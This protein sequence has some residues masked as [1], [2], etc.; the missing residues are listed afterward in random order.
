MPAMAYQGAENSFSQSPQKP[1]LFVEQLQQISDWEKYFEILDFTPFEKEDFLQIHELQYVES[2]FTGKGKLKNTNDIK[3]S[4][5]LV[6]TIRYT[7]ASLFA[8]IEHS[9]LNPLDICC[10]PTAG[11]HHAEPTRG[12]A[13]CTFSGQVLA[14]VKIYEK[15]QKVGAYLDL[16]AHFGNSIED[17][18]EYGNT[19]NLQKAI[20][21]WANFNPYGEGANFMRNYI[22]C[23]AIFKEKAI[24]KEVDYVVWC[25]GADS[26]IG[27]EIG[28]N[29]NEKDWIHCTTLFVQCIKE[30]EQIT[31][32]A[33]PVSYSLFGGYRSNYNEVISL[34][35]AD[36]LELLELTK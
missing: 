7:N 9:I 18:K 25:H 26:C 21:E 10:S 23:L 2:F 11:F 32:Q 12:A 6:T 15:Y 33:F 16:D 19:P 1:K 27:D 17:H 13:F 34:H 31:Q 14:S 28:G 22:D 8:A 29:V 35:L 5:Q 24:A 3:W 20:P 30:I 36:T 4:K